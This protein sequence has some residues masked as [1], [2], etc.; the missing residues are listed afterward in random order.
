M[1]PGLDQMLFPG[2]VRTAAA[3][4]RERSATRWPAPTVVTARRSLAASTERC[5]TREAQRLGT[6]VFEES[7]ARPAAGF[8]RQFG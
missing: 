8:A 4:L 5:R 3:T 1:A 6:H 2:A 7:G